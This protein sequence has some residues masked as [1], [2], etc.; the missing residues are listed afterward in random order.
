MQP[1]TRGRTRK[2]AAIE[3]AHASARLLRKGAN[4]PAVHCRRRAGGRA[5][6]LDVGLEAITPAKP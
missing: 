2:Y 3:L 1:L 5:G 6:N 4:L